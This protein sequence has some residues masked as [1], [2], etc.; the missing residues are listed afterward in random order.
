MSKKSKR[1]EPTK[2][3]ER[4]V[5]FLLLIILLGLVATILVV[6]LAMLGLTPGI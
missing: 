4:L 6:A 5:P 3:S 2:W 1:F